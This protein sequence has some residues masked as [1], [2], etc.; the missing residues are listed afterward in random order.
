MGNYTPRKQHEPFDAEQRRAVIRFLTDG[1]FV[2]ASH[3]NFTA[4]WMFI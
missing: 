4:H 2:A 3:D 1:W